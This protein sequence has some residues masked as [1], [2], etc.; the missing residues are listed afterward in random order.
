MYYRTPSRTS[1][2]LVRFIVL[3][4]ATIFFAILSLPIWGPPVL[5]RIYL[6]NWDAR[7]TSQM[8]VVKSKVE[9]SWPLLARSAPARNGE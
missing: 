6:N 5:T 1:P 8:L 3:L 7:L 9:N 2:L 4:V